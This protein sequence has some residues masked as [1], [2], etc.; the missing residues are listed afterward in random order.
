MEY[1]LYGKYEIEY[2]LG[3]ITHPPTKP[4]NTTMNTKHVLALSLFLFALLL[5]H[6]V[7]A[8]EIEKVYY[9]GEAK[10]SSPKGESRGSQAFLLV[11][12]QDPDN[13]TII[14]RAVI[15]KP[16]HSVEDHTL[17]MKVTGD[18]F[19]IVDGRNTIHGTGTLFG[20]AWK[21]TYFKA[22]YQSTA[23]VTIE[24][25]DFM[26]DPGALVARKK[27]FT[28]DGT[29]VMYMDITLKTV[30]P[31]TFSIISE[32]LLKNGTEHPSEKRS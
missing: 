3:S 17:T 2:L 24:D 7:H 9:V 26:T 18:K 4:A 8:A 30:T 6:A 29:V 12:T 13:N 15:V 22:I 16:D 11:K 21:W 25:E 14:E 10:L 5:P 27:I 23:G 28:P 20:P 31:A 1:L 19:T 32:S